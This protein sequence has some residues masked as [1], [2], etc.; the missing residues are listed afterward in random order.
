MGP[1]AAAALA[2][3]FW[4]GG[5]RL[6]AGPEPSPETQLYPASEEP[7]SKPVKPTTTYWKVAVG[8]RV[9][10][11]EEPARIKMFVPMSDGRQ[12]VVSRR[13][14]GENLKQEEGSDGTNLWSVW[15][16]AAAAKE[17]G[18]RRVA[19]EMAIEISDLQ[20]PP[21]Q[22]SL[23]RNR[24]PKDVAPYLQ[25]SA[26]IQSADPLV[27]KRVRTLVGGAT[28]VDEIAWTLYQYSASFLPIETT[29]AP[30]DALSVL[31]AQRG[32]SAGRSRVLVALL[33]NAGIPARLVG[34][35]RL[36]DAQRKRSTVAW[37]EAY[38]DGRWIP[39]DPAGGHFASLPNNYLALYRGDLPLITHTAG[40]E[41]DYD[42]LIHRSTRKAV[43]EKP[44]SEEV[45]EETPGERM[46][47]QAWQTER[48][49]TVAV[50]AD[51]P[52]ASVLL[53]S[54]DTIPE[55][56]AERMTGVAKE[57]EFDLVLLNARFESR[58]FRG[59]YLQKLTSANLP[60]IRASHLVLVSTRDEAGLYS[61]L[62]LGEKRV[63]LTD[64]RIV[65]AGSFPL[66]VGKTLGAVLFSLTEPGELV[67]VN[68]RTPLLS[69]WE[70]ALA[71]LIDGV[72][73]EAAASRWGIRPLVMSEAQ[74]ASFSA[75][76]RAVIWAW[77]RAVQAQVPLQALS[78]ILVLP[79]IA[80]LVVIGRTI[81]GI[82][83]F[84]T[85]A[86][87]IVC[88]AFL[89]TGLLWGLVIFVVIVGL[90]VLLR[91][92]LQRLRLQLVARLGVLVAM[93]AAIMAGLTVAGAYLGIGALL[94]VSVFPMVIMSVVIEN[95]TT[96]QVERGTAAAIKLTFNTL[97]M[98]AA[99]YVLVEAASLRSLLLG[100][101]ELLLVVVGMEVTLGKWR[102]LRLLEYLRFYELVRSGAGR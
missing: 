97:F 88:V 20:L 39:L 78:L 4:A 102:G 6:W 100:F 87:V 1:F 43:L 74:V 11:P 25:P 73:M 15:H 5:T 70:M 52:V 40:L 56:V 38:M 27:G 12:S 49:S 8:L 98:C 90:G 45:V 61:L 92:A 33:R 95:F 30:S 36:K 82:E 9:T 94:N 28:R 46:R 67:V 62:E 64:A 10:E 69:L 48:V 81:I 14:M 57:R 35:L 68:R 47:E 84:G 37:V 89:M 19:M 50:Y 3:F 54:D 17:K 18:R 41:L 23:K 24:V 99:S 16:M 58:Y 59:T 51:R 42:F 31:K 93:V 21:P 63:A 76:R 7:R 71:N 53:M 60:L 101:P 26:R 91:A 80:C 29:D 65:V 85:F 2:L 66:A 77:T 13:V 72:P 86:P 44:E 34:G 32:T 22:I 55:G 96:S 75:W 79:V 83:T